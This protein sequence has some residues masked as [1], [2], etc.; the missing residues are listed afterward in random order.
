MMNNNSPVKPYF[1][2]VMVVLLVM[3]AL[4]IAL[5]V[6]LLYIQ[7]F[8]RDEYRSKAFD[9][10]TTEMTISPKRGIIYDRNMTPLAVSATV[11][12]VFIS[13]Y[14][15]LEE[16]EDKIADYLSQK[17]GVN[18]AEIVERMSRKQKVENVLPR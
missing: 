17:L 11:E 4:L 7:V 6:R 14:E 1:K 16:D 2:R 8:Q 15:I 13:P 9:Q 5:A 18:R 12:T 3:F 10:Y